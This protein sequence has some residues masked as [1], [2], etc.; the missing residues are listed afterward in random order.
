MTSSANPHQMPQR[1]LMLLVVLS[2]FGVRA[3]PIPADRLPPGGTWEHVAGVPGGVPLR[4][5]I[6]VN[7]LTTTNPLYKCTADGSTD[8]LTKLGNALN[9][10]P[11][12]Q[13]V[14]LPSGNYF[15][16]GTTGMRSGAGVTLR[17]NGPGNTVISGGAFNGVVQFGSVWP[18]NFPGTVTAITAG[19]VKG[20]TAVTVASAAT[21]AVGQM[22]WLE[23]ANDGIAVFNYGSSSSYGD[24]RTRDGSH[25][26]NVRAMVT[27]ITG[28][29]VSFLPPLPCSLLVSPE[30]IGFG[31]GV[32]CSW[33]GLE[34][35]TINGSTA[36]TG[37]QWDGAYACWV[38]NV[39]L[40]NWENFGLWANYAS[41]CSIDQFYIHQPAAFDRS[42][43]YSIEYDDCDH[44][45]LVNSILWH[46]ETGMLVQESVANLFDYNFA[47]DI[48]NGYEGSPQRAWYGSHVP[49]TTMNAFIFNEGSGFQNDFYFGPS[50]YALLLGNLFT[51]SEPSTTTDGRM[52]ISLDSHSCSN[53]VIGN[54]LGAAYTNAPRFSVLANQAVVYGLP[55]PSAPAWRLG[56]TNTDNYTTGS[57][58]FRLGYPFSGNNSSDGVEAD[59]GTNHPTYMDATVAPSTLITNNWDIVNQTAAGTNWVQAVAQVFPSGRPAW[60]DATAPWPPFDPAHP[61]SVADT[62]LPAARRFWL[63][64]NYLAAPAPFS[65]PL[66]LLNGLEFQVKP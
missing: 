3:Q 37:F 60:Y 39:E 33:C 38:K 43:G 29:V 48:T 15:V 12:N 9:N 30:A 52:V 51:G 27:N 28:N 55:S 53:S 63:G 59:G 7:V 13:V 49:Y 45:H 66:S 65:F 10:C 22:L 14:F 11:S 20:S 5:T 50:S 4:T 40:V 17:G 46:G 21:F 1:I 34:D 56:L 62:N 44:L 61:A 25:C 47:Y 42:F 41:C 35:L 24:D 32:V 2:T 19:A 18:P 57:S 58:V 26:L 54:I 31:G 8:N 23:Q 64:T 16:S 6:F 36:G